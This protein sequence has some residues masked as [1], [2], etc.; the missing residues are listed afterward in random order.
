MKRHSIVQVAIFL[1]LFLGPFLSF[2]D[3][4]KG[5]CENISAE[6]VNYGIARGELKEEKAAK[7]GETAAGVFWNMKNI[8]FLKTTDKFPFEE[9]NIMYLEYQ[10]SNLPINVKLSDF[11]KVIIYPEP[12]MVNPDGKVFKKTDRKFG[13]KAKNSRIT[14]RTY[15]TFTNKYPFEMVT[16]KWIWQIRR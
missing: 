13:I 15:W 8:K 4:F 2:A 7:K 9:G 16:G 14:K 12:G 10:L 1:C 11:R 3:T 5:T 6:I